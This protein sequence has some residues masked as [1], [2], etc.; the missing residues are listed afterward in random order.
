MKTYR[1][2]PARISLDGFRELIAAR[3]MLPAR[4]VLHELL[5]ER[6][7]ILKETGI[8]HLG[9]L[10][11]RIST[12]TRLRKFALQT[13]LP[14]NYLAVLKREAGSYLARPFPLSAF[15]GIPFEY[16]ELLK[17]RGLSNTGKFFEQA[18]TG[19]QQMQLSKDTGI[20]VYRIRELYCLCDLSRIG[21]VGAL[22]ARV[23]YEAGIRSAGDFAQSEA[24]S[25]LESCRQVIDKHAFAAGKLGE[26]DMQY[27]IN[28]ARVVV[29]NDQKSE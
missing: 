2:D 6:F 1:I 5:E 11:A 25:L 28:Y 26:K 27:G 15:P 21:G 23:L 17:S 18:Q 29:A 14:E 24:A 7:A 8:Q 4:I 19:E 16:T 9:D 13:G 12:R 20:P 22:F 10:L 3:E